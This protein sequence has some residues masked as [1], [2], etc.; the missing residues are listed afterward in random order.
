MTRVGSQRHKKNAVKN[1]KLHVA[2]K[3]KLL[4]SLNE[5]ETWNGSDNLYRNRMTFLW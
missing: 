4:F 5:S 3:K 1:Y 2:R